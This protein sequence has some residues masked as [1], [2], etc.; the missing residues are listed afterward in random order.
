LVEG[1]LAILVERT[2]N[3]TRAGVVV[4]LMKAAPVH[5]TRVENYAAKFANIAVLP[6]LLIGAG[7]FAFTGDLART[8][9]I[10]TLDFGTGIRRICPHR[11]LSRINIAARTRGLHPRRQGDRNVGKSRLRRL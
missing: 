11:R 2:G 5:D 4:E 10:I 1:Q 3:N 6:T 7:I 9:A 8:T